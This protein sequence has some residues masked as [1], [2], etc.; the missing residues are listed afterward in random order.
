M[1][2][3]LL[4]APAA[5]LQLLGWNAL[6]RSSRL[7]LHS[8]IVLLYLVPCTPE[9]GVRLTG[10]RPGRGTVWVCINGVW[11][12][13][14]DNYWNIPDARVVCKQL[15]YDGQG[16]LQNYMYYCYLDL[17]YLIKF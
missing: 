5:I 17:V 1:K 12:T 3:T 4:K 2:K 10:D 14:C 6:V 15:G 16:I 13:V 8:I 7:V 9:G 11:S